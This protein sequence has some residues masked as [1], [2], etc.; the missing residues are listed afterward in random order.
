MESIFR[1]IWVV[2]FEFNAPRG[3]NPSPLCYVAKNLISGDTIRQWLPDESCM[4]YET[5]DNDLFVAYYA[6]AE[7]SCHLALGWPIPGNILDLYVEFRN[8]TNGN[9]TLSK[10][11]SLLDVANTLGIDASSAAHKEMMRNLILS[12]GPF[13]PAQKDEILNYCQDDV[14]ITSKIF[15]KLYSNIDIVR[16]LLRGRY[17]AAVAMMEWN[18]IPIDPTAYQ[19]LKSNYESLKTALIE[20]IDE[21]FGVYE[22]TT[23]KS[24]KFEA[25]LRNR[26]IRWEYTP[27][28][29]ISLSDEVFKE[30]AKTYPE[31][32]PLRQLR[33]FLGQL[34]LHDLPV[35][36]DSRNRTML[37]PFRTK[38]GRNAPSSSAYIFG[39]AT[40][41]RS[42]IRPEPG[43]S[44]AYIDYEQQE[45]GIAAALSG[46][47]ALQ[48]AYTSGDPYITF[49]I[50]A[51]ILPSHATKATHPKE[52]ERFKI[53]FLATQ[54]GMQEKTL[55]RIAAL[56]VHHARELLRRHRMVYKRFW[57]WSD[58]ILDRASL[59]GKLTTRY[60]WQL[61]TKTERERTLRNFPMQAHGAEILRLACCLCLEDGIKV[62][63][64]VHDA[65]LIE[66]P[67]KDIESTVQRAQTQM[68][69]ASEYVL[70][71]FPLRTE[72]QVITYP[73]RYSDKRGVLMWDTIGELLG[74]WE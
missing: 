50:Q 55:A 64:P 57:E 4:R 8:L 2:D 12:G 70:Q 38:T 66:S 56:P 24:A 7:I 45:I 54:Y 72:A 48:E 22:G 25:W 19:K 41:L 68:K 29:R 11:R 27:K 14:E 67:T 73:D 63:A 62:C 30:Y 17:M 1:N 65:L 59:T 71:Q 23:F 20:R 61:Q 47:P 69:E 74:G 35:G 10:S 46:D 32:E 3:E 34:K 43:H 15:E 42:L 51:G 9:P 6:S 37:S 33:Y 28:G 52:R 53:C 5:T 36:S 21:N 18:G 49:G 31:L 16:A 44:L 13:T 60:G 58:K 40:W 39:P 26:G